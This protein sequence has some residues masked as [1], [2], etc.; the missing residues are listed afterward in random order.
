MIQFIN[1]F[2]LLLDHHC[3]MV[4]H[5]FDVAHLVEYFVVLFRSTLDLT[6][7]QV[8]LNDKLKNFLCSD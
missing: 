7:G 8:L 6:A 4:V 3:N 2:T 5:F 1:V